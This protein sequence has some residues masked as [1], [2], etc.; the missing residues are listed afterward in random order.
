[1]LDDPI[2]SRARPDAAPPP[3]PILVTGPPRSGSTWVGNVL[4][5]DGRSGYVHEP[6][7]KNCTA[8]RCRADFRHGFT[9]VTHAN[10]APYLAP[11]RDTLA[12]KYSLMAEIREIRTPRSLARMARDFTYYEIMRQRG[13]RMIMKDPMALLSADWIADRFDARVVVVIRRPEGFVA[14]MRAAGWGRFPFRIL[15]DQPALMAERLA[16][17]AEEMEA[18][19]RNMPDAIDAGTLLWRILHHH[20]DLLRREHPDW[21]FV[22]HEDLS[23][24]P[25]P[26][27]RA[28]FDALG[29]DFTETVRAKLVDFTSGNGG[30]L[31]RLSPFGTTRRTL[32][33]SS[34]S[35]DRVRSRL[36]A[37][38]IA[39]I[40]T[41]TAPLAATFYPEEVW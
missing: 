31:S 15:L 4:S 17:F 35:L 30:G 2:H 27:F 41:A 14:S 29:L 38:E 3:A 37:A 33:S 6:F 24:D 25:E 28:L 20:I 9:Y 11:L 5:L 7:N 40:R 13:V 16:P 18:A 23:R 19:R 10:E 1:M 34:D 22:R 36:T 8:G 32:R 12:W 39:R 26:G 21:I